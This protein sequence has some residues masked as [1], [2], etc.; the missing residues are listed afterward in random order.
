MAVITPRAGQLIK[1]V[2]APGVYRQCHKAKI[3]STTLKSESVCGH[4]WLNSGPYPGGKS[5]VSCLFCHGK[6]LHFRALFG[7]ASRRTGIFKLK[8]TRQ[9]YFTFGKDFRDIPTSLVPDIGKLV[10]VREMS[11]LYA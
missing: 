2:L 5:R 8:D 10:T 3:T 7:K 11:R 1:M 6:V 4:A 9:S